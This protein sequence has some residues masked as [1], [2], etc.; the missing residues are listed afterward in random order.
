MFF[1]SANDKLHLLRPFFSCPYFRIILIKLGSK[2]QFVCANQSILILANFRGSHL[3][4]TLVKYLPICPQ[5]EEDR[6]TVCPSRR[7]VGRFSNPVGV[8]AN[9]NRLSI[10][11][12]GLFSEAQKSEGREVA[13]ALRRVV[14]YLV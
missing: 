3:D 11:L 2:L 9:I 12:S 1:C 10:S 13:T 6:L 14:V 8:G 5:A 4:E 7:A